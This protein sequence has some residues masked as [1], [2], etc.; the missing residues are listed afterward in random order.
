MSM[1]ELHTS[2]GQVIF[3]SP[4]DHQWLGKWKW[5]LLHNGYV[6]RQIY[7]GGG[8]KNKKVRIIR[9]HHL[10]MPK[11]N[12]LDIDHI[13]GNRA[14]NRR[15]NLRYCTRAENLWNSRK[16]PVGASGYRGVYEY[17]PGRFQC[18]IMANGRRIVRNGFSSAEDA[19]AARDLLAVQ[20]HGD[21]AVLNRDVE[22][23]AEQ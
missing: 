8:R 13:N 14:D 3:V 12:G 6:G 11:I 4:G 18:H 22:A 16:N 20:L 1:T 2:K 19:A 17:H 23:E 15:E 5:K 9:M 7:V 10:I 21:F